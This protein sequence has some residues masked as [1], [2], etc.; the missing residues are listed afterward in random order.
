MR[1]L[2]YSHYRLG[3]SRLR[4][5]ARELRHTDGVSGFVGALAAACREDDDWRL[6]QTLPPHRWE[7]WFRHD[8]GWRSVRP[9]ATIE[10]AHRGR[11]LSFLLEY[12][13]RARN[14]APMT[15]KLRRYRHYLGVADTR[16]DFDGR[17]PAALLVFADEAAASRFCTLAARAL[18]IPLPLLVS[19]MR[20]IT[21]AGPLGRAWRSPWRLQQGYVSRLP[22]RPEGRVRGSAMHRWRAS[23][24]K[25]AAM[26]VIERMCHPGDT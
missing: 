6:R 1:A 12:E 11:R 20:T 2:R 26:H 19:D 9:D 4:V 3:G 21:E 10:L 25:N 22:R 18:E 15:A 13:E 23:H 8:T 14:P 17:R 5:L 7:R 24:Q 16:A